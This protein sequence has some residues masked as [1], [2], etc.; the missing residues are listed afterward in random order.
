MDI[1][2][3]RFPSVRFVSLSEAF[4]NGF[5]ALSLV[6]TLTMPNIPPLLCWIDDRAY[7][8]TQAHYGGWSKINFI[9]R[10]YGDDN[11]QTYVPAS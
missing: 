9:C 1:F 10:K 5:Y 2:R 7:A 11:S 3:L 4:G 6:F 8:M